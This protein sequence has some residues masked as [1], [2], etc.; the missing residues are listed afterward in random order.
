MLQLSPQNIT[1]LV[2]YPGRVASSPT[3]T[4]LWNQHLIFVSDQVAFPTDASEAYQYLNQALNCSGYAPATIAASGDAA[5]VYNCLAIASFTARSGSIINNETLSMNGPV[6]FT[7]KQSGRIGGVIFTQ[8]QGGVPATVISSYPISSSST[9]TQYNTLSGDSG[10]VSCIWNYIAITD[11][12]GPH[13]SLV[14]VSDVDLVQGNTYSLFGATF[15]F[16]GV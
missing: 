8:L 14:V 15:K 13:S 16:S 2:N 6:E 9:L 11:S 7:A 5:Y 3:G 1:N 4:S 10:N 12:V